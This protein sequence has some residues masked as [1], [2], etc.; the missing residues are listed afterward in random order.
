MLI[1]TFQALDEVLV[2][3][4]PGQLRML[5]VCGVV[6][7]GAVDLLTG[8]EV[9]VN[10]F[11]AAPVAI[12]AWYVGRRA[13]LGIALLCSLTVYIAEIG[14]KFSHPA[15]PVWNALIRLGFFLITGLLL[16]ALRNSFLN[17][18][19]LAQT[20]G[21]TELFSRRAFGVRLDH[22]L[23]LA[24]RRKSPITIAY[25]D[26]DNFK[27]VNDTYGHAEGDRVLRMT[28]RVL[29]RILRRVDTAA[30]L[31]G[32]EF[33]LV[34]PDTGSHGAQQIISKLSHAF[35]EACL[36]TG[37]EMTFSM[38]VI[39]VLDP[40]VSTEQAISAADA[41]MYE[42]K[43]QG[44]GAASFRVLGEAVQSHT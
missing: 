31:G 8:Y 15:I 37:I 20:D 32:D 2:R 10:L 3:R 4:T 16:A 6:M 14:N 43:R 39:T 44:K 38:G 21:L 26:L 9:S 33:A 35:Q 36:A 19:R 28:G 18:Q 5:A 11:Y 30:R 17:E 41:L 25:M 40:T 27:A 22:D 23:A 34:L 29:T 42:V 13:G 24:Q 1:T 12:A 7:V